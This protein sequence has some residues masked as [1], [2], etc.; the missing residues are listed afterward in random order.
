MREAAARPRRLGATARL[1]R[2]HN[3][4]E[5]LFGDVRAD[6]CDTRFEFG[7]DGRPF[8]VAGPTDTAAQVR[9]RLDRLRRSV[10]EEG[11]DFADADDLEEEDDALDL[12]L[13]GEEGLFEGYDPAR[14]PDAGEW[15]ALDEDERRLRVEHYHRRA[16][17]YTGHDTVHATLH[18][19]IESHIASDDPPAARRALERLRA[20]GLDRH[21]AIHAMGSVVAELIYDLMEGKASAPSSPDD[22]GA[23][24]DRL[25]AEGWRR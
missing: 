17:L 16:G 9:Q 7:R 15:L 21:E 18:V 14:E 11:F 8:Y 12:A 19:V 5:R 20:E 4:A 6:T 13:A 10:G 24:L 2:E 23:A 3:A 25:T 1:P 22:Y